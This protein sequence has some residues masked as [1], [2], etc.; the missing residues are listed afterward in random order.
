MARAALVVSALLG[1]LAMHGLPAHAAAPG[2]DHTAHAA[3]TTTT[4]TLDVEDTACVDHTACVATT[5]A[6]EHL[7]PPVAVST[8]QAPPVPTT[9]VSAS[10]PDLAPSAPPDQVDLVALGISRT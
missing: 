1:L 7:A 4:A 10:R 9:T 8:T 6:S 3:A 5:R 2:P